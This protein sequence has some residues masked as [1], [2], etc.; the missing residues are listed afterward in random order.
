MV[1]VTVQCIVLDGGG[2]GRAGR[3]AYK[4]WWSGRAWVIYWLGTSVRQGQ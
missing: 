2:V 4:V 1:S 3:Q